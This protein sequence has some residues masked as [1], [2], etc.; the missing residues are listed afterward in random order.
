MVSTGS[1]E[2]AVE[3]QVRK[4]RTLLRPRTSG[5]DGVNQMLNSGYNVQVLTELDFT[6]RLRSSE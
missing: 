3:Q 2:E 6:Q 1:M 4:A 5:D